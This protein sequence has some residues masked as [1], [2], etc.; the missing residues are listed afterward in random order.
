[1][2]LLV[3]PILNSHKNCIADS[4]ENNEQDV[5]SE[6]IRKIKFFTKFGFDVHLFQLLHFFVHTN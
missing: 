4:K 3:D 5:E 6:R 1:M 2:G